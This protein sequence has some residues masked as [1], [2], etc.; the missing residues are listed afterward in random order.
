MKILPFLLVC[1]VVTLSCSVSPKKPN[2]K[3]DTCSNC[4]MQL[5][6]ELFITQTVLKKN[7]LFF[8]SVECVAAY[9]AKESLDFQKNQ[10]WVSH[11]GTEKGWVPLTSAVFVQTKLVRSPMGMGLVAFRDSSSAQ[12]FNAT[13]NGSVF[14]WNEVV[15]FVAT[16]WQLQN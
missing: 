2:I 4:G 8:E 14:T 3:V 12:E 6:D 16:E 11:F 7:R 1:L 9:S 15:N 5:N 10:S 13:V